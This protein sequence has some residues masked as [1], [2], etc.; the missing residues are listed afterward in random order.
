MVWVVACGGDAFLVAHP[1]KREQITTRRIKREA[2]LNFLVF[3]ISST[4]PK[5]F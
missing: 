2:I 1:V 3:I 5:E 4:P